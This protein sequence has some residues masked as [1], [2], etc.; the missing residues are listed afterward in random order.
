M[1][2]LCLLYHTRHRSSRPVWGR[3]GVIFTTHHL[4]TTTHNCGWL[5]R[6][7][8]SGV[9][10]YRPLSHAGSRIGVPHVSPSLFL[11]RRPL[12]RS[13]HDF[14]QC[15][16]PS[17]PI[18]SFSS[19]SDARGM[20]RLNDASASPP[21]PPSSRR[22]LPIHTHNIHPSHRQSICCPRAAVVCRSTMRVPAGLWLKA[23]RVRP[24]RCLRHTRPQA[25]RGGG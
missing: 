13:H 19:S 12:W 8:D 6:T 17:P 1:V 2:L 11:C 21:P 7:G 9:Y 22:L 15:P 25:Q 20:T 10:V 24:A 4:P 3:G 18:W 23:R 5:A 16:P 14:P